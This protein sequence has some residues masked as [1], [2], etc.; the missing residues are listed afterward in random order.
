MPERSC[1]S[2][3]HPTISAAARRGLRANAAPGP[4]VVPD[5]ATWYAAPYKVFDDLYF[6]GTKIH[7]AWALT[8]SDGIIV[9]D[10]LFDYA[11]EPEMV[12]G[13]DQAR[14]RSARHQIRADQ[15]C[16]RRSRSRR[17]AAAE[18]LRREGRDGR[19]RLGLDAAAPR[20]GRGRRAEARH[21]GRTGRPRDQARRHHRQ[22]RRNSRPHA[23]HAFLH[24]S[25]EGREPDVDGGL[26]GR[27]GLQLPAERARTSRSTATA[28]ARWRKPRA[29]PAPPC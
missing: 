11:I 3:S 7:S 26:F 6:I 4:R 9:I 21:L 15:P 25:R 20:N 17:G 18:P 5:R 27:H 2:A 29:R 8:T 16:A 12:D 19:G 1:A 10:T 28:R 13:I 14:P 24:L 23:G 22:R